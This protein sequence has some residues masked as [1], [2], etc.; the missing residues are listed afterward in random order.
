MH[1]KKLYE[2]TTKENKHEDIEKFIKKLHFKL[3]NPGIYVMEKTLMRYI[4]LKGIRKFI[5]KVCS[6]CITC[7]TEKENSKKYGIPIYNHDVTKKNEAIGIDLKGLISAT[8]FE[9]AD[10]ENDFYV[11]V[12]VDIFTQFSE[13]ALLF[14]I[15]SKTV[16]DELKKF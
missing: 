10:F 16:C 2:I 13:I 8:M 1:R 11:L 5:K 4:K 9:N 15:D 14:N 3:V 7:N 12:V 6:D